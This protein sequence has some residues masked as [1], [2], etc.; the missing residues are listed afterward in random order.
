MSKHG[1][2]CGR[3]ES[4]STTQ[5]KQE[6]Q[7]EQH[8]DGQREARGKRKA[9]KSNT[10]TGQGC[11]P[12]AT[13]L[14]RLDPSPPSSTHTV[15]FNFTRALRRVPASVLLRSIYKTKTRFFHWIDYGYCTTKETGLLD[16]EGNVL[17]SLTN[18]TG[19]AHWWIGNDLYTV[20]IVEL[21]VP[22]CCRLLCSCW[23]I[24]A[25]SKIL[26][27]ELIRLVGPIG[28]IAALLYHKYIGC[29]G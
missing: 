4:T 16:V 11:A 24:R 25:R 26:C 14:S 3:V 28:Q 29:T 21:K 5:G 17:I 23:H 1:G 6:Q 27:P 20:V 22:W 12:P 15:L 8:V 7:A 2:D 19:G 10:K 13:T 18:L 9:T